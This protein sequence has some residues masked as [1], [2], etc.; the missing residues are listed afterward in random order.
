MFCPKCGKEIPDQAVFCPKCGASI[1]ASGGQPRPSPTQPAVPS[2][3]SGVLG[4]ATLTQRKAVKTLLLILLL[5]LILAGMWMSGTFVSTELDG[6]APVPMTLVEDFFQGALTKGYILTCVF[7]LLAPII[8]GGF[9]GR[10]ILKK[11]GKVNIPILPWLY[12]IWAAGFHTVSFFV[13]KKLFREDPEYP[14]GFTFST[15]GW[16]YNLLCVVLAVALVY[17]T[18]LHFKASKERKTQPTPP[19]KP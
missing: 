3:P 5:N 18:V 11:D 7:A 8:S 9:L 16:L 4:A 1:N 6:S 2:K 10:H 17:L 14:L 19:I 15:L 12:W 13:W